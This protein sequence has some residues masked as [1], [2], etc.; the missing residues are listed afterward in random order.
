MNQLRMV[1][2]GKIIFKRP[3]KAHIFVWEPK[4]DFNLGFFKSD[5][6]K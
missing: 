4:E 3:E 5:I 1:E 6:K 2:K